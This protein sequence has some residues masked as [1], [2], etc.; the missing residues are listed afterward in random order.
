MAFTT[1][2]LV[3]LTL[4]PALT[5][6]DVVHFNSRQCKIPILIDPAQR[7]KIKQLILFCAAD[8][9]HKQWNQVG[10][11]VSPDQDAFTFYAPQD[12]QYWFTITVVDLQNNQ[13]PPDPLN[14][15][16]SLKME[17]DTVKP[18]VNL[19][20]ER[21]NDEIQVEWDIREEHVDWNLTTLDYRSVDDSGSSGTP[22]PVTTPS[23]RGRANF[24]YTG[25]SGVV[26][27][28][29]VRDQAG[30]KALAERTVPASPR[31]SP[32]E[33]STGPAPAPPNR[34]P[35]GNAGAGS[36]YE[37]NGLARTVNTEPM[38]PSLPMNPPPSYPVPPAMPPGAPTLGTSAPAP[39]PAGL[40]NQPGVVATTAMNSNFAPPPSA[41]GAP[42]P[43]GP[44]RGVQLTN[45]KRF[46]LDC[47]V[48]Q[49]GPSGVS[50]VE[51]YISPDNGQTWNWQ[52]H[53]EQRELQPAADGSYKVSIQVEMPSEGVYGFRLVVSNGAGLS[54]GPPQP[55]DPPEIRIEYDATMPFAQLYKPRYEQE[56]PNVLILTWTAS[57]RNLDPS[58]VSLEWSVDREGTRG[59]NLIT[60]ERLPN[61]GRYDWVVPPGGIVPPRVYLRL[62]VRD[63]SGNVSYAVTQEAQVIDL[64][65]P[66]GVIKG[67]VSFRQP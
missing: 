30:N 7:G 55:S 50:A 65:R 58:P 37:N 36:P 39:A 19:M 61:K 42:A 13:Q 22:V 43:M 24:R 28:M 64:H 6:G 27:R 18:T 1:L 60:P 66:V 17:I 38:P 48:P 10:P 9:E 3:W 47:E 2:T 25:L 49:T 57:D 53:K 4:A 16:P 44:A 31:P 34:F 40:D 20:A 21:R 63:A 8:P 5:P 26:V 46:S 56:K 41:P 59:W 14:A 29:E 54:K 33:F 45:Q 12:G 67:I 35:T 51:L 52:L 11:P 15:P 62:T 23:N 32:A